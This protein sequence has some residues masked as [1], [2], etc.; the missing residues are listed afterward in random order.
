LEQQKQA[1]AGRAQYFAELGPAAVAVDESLR[2]FTSKLAD[3]DDMLRDGRSRGYAVP[4]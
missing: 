1:A 2:S 3:L 4:S